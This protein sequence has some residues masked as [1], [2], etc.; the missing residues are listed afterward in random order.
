VSSPGASPLTSIEVV[1]GTP[2]RT[3]CEPEPHARRP[4]ARLAFWRSPPDQPR[5]ARPVL[6]IVAA[7]AGVTYAWRLGSSTEIFYAAADRSMSM[8]WHNFF[9]AAF[10]PDATI[11][12]DKL[13]G[14]FWLQAAAVRVFGPHTW[15][16]ALPQVLEGVLCV[17][18]LFRVVRRCA[19]PMAGIGAA[20]LLAFSPAIVTLDRGNVADTLLVLLLVLAADAVVAALQTG[21]HAHLLLAGVWVGLAFQAKMLEAWL[22]LPALLV[23]YLVAGR[24]TV[25]RRVA[26]GG[27]MVAIAVAVS[28]S[29]MAAVTLT[30]SHDR[31]YVDGTTNDSVVAQVFDYNGFAR[32]GHLSPNQQ[33]G[34]TLGIPFLAAPAPPASWDRLLT[35][36]PGRDTGWLLPAA[37]LTVP[38]LLWTRRRR[39]RTD[40]VRAAALLWG[41]WLVLF[42]VVFSVSAIN[43]YYLGALSPPI[44]AL[45]ATAGA[46]AW[47]RRHLRAVQAGTAGLVVLAVGYAAWLL[48]SSGTG[49]WSGLVWMTLALG[50]LGIGSVAAFAFRSGWPAGV[51]AFVVAAGILLVPLWASVSVVTN[52]LGAFDTP[53][54]PDQVTAFNKAFFGAPLQPIAT[55]PAIER[56]RNGAPD[57]AAAQTSVLAAPFVFATGQEVLPIGGYSGSTP[58]PTL[59][60]LRSA[61]SSGR[62][63]LVLTGASSTDARA[64]WIRTHCIAV[65]PQGPSPAIPVDVSY[66]LPQNA[67]L[68]TGAHG[69]TQSLP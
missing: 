9:Y 47:E 53:F 51:T 30:P 42:A 41:T 14:A 3:Q 2:A 32:V 8:S 18:V 39:K 21:S 63:H 11:S 49:V 67:D 5:W 59:G 37:A 58:E 57:L 46:Q 16:V 65:K 35:G 69:Q 13:P 1:E 28:F 15:A 19:G 23:T 56:V 6:L 52:D 55:L 26:W 24:A 66:C 12:L 68:P 50:A 62:F 25:G 36:A 33:L 45:V 43:W 54:Q 20:G 7:V 29:W 60:A 31:P 40:A 22:V 64:R 17:L 44:A 61:I 48:P 38:A 27:A 4:V 10:D 34:R